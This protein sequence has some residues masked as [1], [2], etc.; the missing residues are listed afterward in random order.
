MIYICS[1]L[2]A[3]AKHTMEENIEQAKAICRHCA[4]NGVLA[5]AV[6]L[7]F[8]QILDDLIEEE[9]TCGIQHGLTMLAMCKEVWVFGDIISSGMQAEIELAEKLNIPIKYIPDIDAWLEVKNI[10]N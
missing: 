6:H 2:R 4:V 5:M 10:E 1:P 3:N 9:R 8:T 7:Y